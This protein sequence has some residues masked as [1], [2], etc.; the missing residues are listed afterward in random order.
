VDQ[1]LKEI[2]VLEVERQCTFGLIA[3]RDLDV[4]LQAGDMDRIW[5]SVQALLIAVGNL[6][7]LL[8]PLAKFEQRGR[9]LRETF[10]LKEDSALA[11]R[12]FRN[13]FEHFDERL[14]DWAT[15]SRH[16]NFVDSNVGPPN[17][18]VGI[19]AEDFLRNFDTQDVAV[20][21]RGDHYL[22]IP[23]VNAIAEIYKVCSA[24]KDP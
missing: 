1:H 3:T 24:L 2:F 19:D 18:V 13:H 16:R 23:I 7:K 5:Y 4:A 14:E 10:N 6:S 15:S 8:W 22:L 17:M 21:F 12:K 20:T 11:P 9:A